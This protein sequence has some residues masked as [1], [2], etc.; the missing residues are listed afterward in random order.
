VREGAH[1]TFKGAGWDPAGEEIEI[2]WNGEKVATHP[3]ATSI[4]T[5]STTALPCN[6]VR[7]V[8]DAARSGSACGD[9]ALPKAKKLDRA[10][11]QVEA[12]SGR[13]AKKARRLYKTAKRLLAKASK[14]AASGRRPTLTVER[15]DELREAI[16]ASIGLLDAARNQSP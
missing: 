13:P 11:A 1:V 14:K 5:T 2:F 15:V 12:A 8:I 3:A 9:E 16:S 4:G 7:C 6:T 10:I